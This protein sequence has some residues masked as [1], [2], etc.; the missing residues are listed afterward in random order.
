MTVMRDGRPSPIEVNGS[1]KATRAIRRA[2]AFGA[3]RFRVILSAMRAWF[4]LAVVAVACELVSGCGSSGSPAPRCGSLTGA[5]A[6]SCR[7]A[8]GEAAT[9]VSSIQLPHGAVRLDGEPTGDGGLLKVRCV[10]AA[11]AGQAC[12][13]GWWQVPEPPSAVISFVDRHPPT[14]SSGK[15]TLGGGGDATRTE[16]SVIFTARTASPAGSEVWVAATAIGGGKTGVL[17]AGESNWFDFLSAG[18]R[19]PAEAHVVRITAGTLATSPN[20]RSGTMQCTPSGRC[21]PC[22]GESQVP[23]LTCPSRRPLVLTVTEPSTVQRIIDRLNGLPKVPRLAT[24]NCDL[25]AAITRVIVMNFR[26][27]TGKTLAQV[28]YTDPYPG[29]PAEAR[30]PCSQALLTV[31]GR[32][33]IG[34]FGGDLTAGIGHLI[35][36]SLT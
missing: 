15:G 2:L 32:P 27:A 34:L 5:A 28:D 24:W 29:D 19:I 6:V 14:N 3:S 11:G 25:P 35:G 10:G 1:R 4:L 21:G 36:R 16:Q 13:G 22:R 8:Y 7:V 9:L 33:R 17:V 30:G 31:A 23:N 20:S 26:S 12:S 18:E